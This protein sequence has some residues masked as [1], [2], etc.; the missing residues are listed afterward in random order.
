MAKF[1]LTATLIVDADDDSEAW[2]V[3]DA[4]LG[5]LVWPGAI[6]AATVGEV[7]ELED[8]AE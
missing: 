6:E 1:Q 2:S 8:A 7:K 3:T 5:N 4:A